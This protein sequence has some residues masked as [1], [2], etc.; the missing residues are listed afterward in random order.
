MNKCKIVRRKLVTFI[1]V[2][3]TAVLATHEFGKGGFMLNSTMFTRGK[4][5][6]NYFLEVGVK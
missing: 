6:Y 3:W 4:R 2:F 5:G 1:P